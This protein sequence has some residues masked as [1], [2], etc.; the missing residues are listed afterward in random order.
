MSPVCP[1]LDPCLP[2]PLW[3]LAPPA[4]VPFWGGPC[5]PHAVL[6]SCLSYLY[7][8]DPILS[9]FLPGFYPQSPNTLL[10][11]VVHQALRAL[12]TVVSSL[13]PPLPQH[14][15]PPACTLIFSCPSP[16][17][18]LVHPLPCLSLR[19]WEIQVRALLVASKNLKQGVT[20]LSPPTRGE[21]GCRPV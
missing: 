16:C 14:T 10:S 18:L 6:I 13:P 21:Q 3:P 15:H 12:A 2:P 19:P 8:C 4:S 5:L 9:L 20:T 17:C 7:P 11:L 1:A